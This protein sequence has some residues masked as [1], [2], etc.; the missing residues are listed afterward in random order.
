MI[1]FS[2]K[3]NYIFLF[4]LIYL[5]CIIFYCVYF[6]KIGNEY[7]LLGLDADT[8]NAYA[9]G[10]LYDKEASN[11]WFWLLK[12]LN[13]LGFY[14]REYVLYI[15]FFINIFLIPFTFIKICL[16]SNYI[17]ST[18]FFPLTMF[19]LIL[20][21]SI[22][23]HSFDIYRDIVM[24][25]VFLIAL[26]LVKLND[27]KLKFSLVF[28]V[29][30]GLILFWFRAYLGLAFLLAYFSSFF[31]NLNKHLFKKAVIYFFILFIFNFLGFFD[32]MIEYRNWFLEDDG[33]TNLGIDF[34]NKIM[35]FP[36][37]IYSATLQLF[38][39]YYYGLSSLILF[40]AE[41]IFFIFSLA[42]VFKNKKYLQDSLLFYF[43]FFIFYTSIWLISNDNF[44]TAIRLRWFSYIPIYILAL[45]I[46]QK[47]NSLS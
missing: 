44:G 20:S 3:S 19:F 46:F 45:S 2:V 1:N 7:I 14:N 37:F 15:I 13:S 23:F 25:F 26:Y 38:G 47:K 17:K 8:Y 18:L 32:P 36:N 27:I 33:N 5:K 35:F 28:V 6:F 41:S 4:F 21:P 30:F 43:L 40:L 10:Y 9:L 22:F 29:L 42:Y 24:L 11:L 16:N 39:F 31:I 12:K 34:S